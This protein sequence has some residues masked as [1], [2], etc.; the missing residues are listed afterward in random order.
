M[1]RSRASRHYGLQTL[2]MES[3][4]TTRRYGALSS[5]PRLAERVPGVLGEHS[6]PE[7]T[8]GLIWRCT[9]GQ[10]EWCPSA[11]VTGAWLSP[12]VWRS[13]GPRAATASGRWEGRRGHGQPSHRGAHLAC[14]EGCSQ[15]FARSASA[16][17]RSRRRQ[18]NLRAGPGLCTETKVPR[19]R[20]RPC[21]VAVGATPSPGARGDRWRC[22]RCE[23][24]RRHRHHRHHVEPMKHGDQGASRKTG[25]SRRPASAAELA[26]T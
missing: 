12:T 4:S 19:N 24:G 7:N 11:R 13:S 9:Y 6:L 1:R 22:R 14:G 8:T 3:S 2:T 20:S 10:N 23:Q 5:A 16:Q 25:P 15:E 21:A 17:H 18:E 26:T